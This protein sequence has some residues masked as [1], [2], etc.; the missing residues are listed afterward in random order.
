MSGFHLS[1]EAGQWNYCL[2][3]FTCALLH[4]PPSGMGAVA[5]SFW[6]SRV[7]SVYVSRDAVYPAKQVRH[8]EMIAQNDTVTY[9][10]KGLFSKVFFLERFFFFPPYLDSVDKL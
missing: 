7:V 6:Q 10:A 4:S 3:I 8:L 2:M 9:I 5:F 1:H